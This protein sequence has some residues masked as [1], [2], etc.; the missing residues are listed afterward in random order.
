[1]YPGSLYLYFK[2]RFPEAEVVSLVKNYRSTQGILDASHELIS[3]NAS[4][5]IERVKLEAREKVKLAN[6]FIANLDTPQQEA[7][8][9]ADD[10]QKRIARGEKANCVEGPALVHDY[11]GGYDEYAE[12]HQSD[13]EIEGR[14]I[15]EKIEKRSQGNG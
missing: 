14:K 9:V 15:K 7:T 2:R 4:G 3:K 11:H 12:A 10:I 5:T 8:F 13:L 1:M 6:I